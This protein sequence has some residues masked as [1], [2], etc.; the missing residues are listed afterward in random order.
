MTTLSANL[1]ILVGTEKSY[2]RN[3]LQAARALII[4]ILAINSQQA[5]KRKVEI[6]QLKTAAML[7]RKADLYQESSPAYAEELRCFAARFEFVPACST[8]AN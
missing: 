1:P 3:V 8:G 4:A 5:A 7:N 6:R 2:G